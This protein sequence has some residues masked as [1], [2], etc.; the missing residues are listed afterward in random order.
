MRLNLFI[1]KTGYASRRKAG[2]LIEEG[3]VKVNDFKV[4]EPFFQVKEKDK[5]KVSGKLL[6]ARKHI[7][8][9][10]NKPKGVTTTVCD[11][12][13]KQKVL[14]FIPKKFNGIYPVGRLDKES[15]GLLIL[16]NDGDLC[17]KLTHP[18]FS[19]EKEYLL[20]LAGNLTSYEC[21]KAKKGVKS[22]GEHLKVDYIKILYRE[23]D[24]SL[25]S[26][27]IC[28]GKKRQLRRLFKAL[29]FIV[30]EIKR[31]RIGKLALGSLKSGEY[32]QI[33][34]SRIYNLCLKK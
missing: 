15:C 24:K 1:S 34:K 7:Y 5:I 2:Q 16:T 11:R 13:A 33:E 20:K 28:E 19:I 12:F 6:E 30:K 10:F 21:R 8:I 18:K 3:K 14:D 25:C 26:V 27:V 4:C 22:E 9:L 29:G 23:N 17:Y 32:R 31:V